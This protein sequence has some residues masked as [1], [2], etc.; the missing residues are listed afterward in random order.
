MADYYGFNPPFIGGAQNVLSRQEDQQ[1]IKND[2]LQLL[3]TVPGE[4][5][6]RPAFGT[7]L[8]AFVF[9]N[10]TDADIE[11][12]RIRVTEA[13][14]THEPRVRVEELNIQQQG[15]GHTIRLYLIARL[16]RDPKTKLTI[17]RF[18]SSPT[19]AG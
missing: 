3:M 9:D 15:D 7:P 18:F 2:L 11:T 8:R 16:V 4:R 5:V 13:I 10:N 17:E 14:R 19:D 6:N 12:L 1:L